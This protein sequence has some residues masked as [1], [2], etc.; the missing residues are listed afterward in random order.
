MFWLLLDCRRIR[1]I[2]VLYIKYINILCVWALCSH[3]KVIYVT[4]AR[5]RGVKYF[6]SGLF[7]SVKRFYCGPDLKTPFYR[8]KHTY[9]Y[10]YSSPNNNNSNNNNTVCKLR[11]V[12]ILN[13]TNNRNDYFN[14]STYFHKNIEQRKGGPYFKSALQLLVFFS[15]RS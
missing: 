13:V 11:F 6:S 9:T 10:R 14:I 15:A 3:N 1:A 7:G 5:I 4:F 8:N 12:T 2:I